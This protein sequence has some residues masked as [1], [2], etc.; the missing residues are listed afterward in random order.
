M[1]WI[2]GL[3]RAFGPCKSRHSSSLQQ[4]SS[5]LTVH[6]D[7]ADEHPCADVQGMDLSPIQ[8]TWV[9]PNCSFYIDDAELDWTFAENWFDFIH[10]RWLA[11]SIRDWP[12]LYRQAMNFLKRGGWFEHTELSMRIKSNIH[13][14]PQVDI[15]VKYSDIFD[16]A[17]RRTGRRFDIADGNQLQEWMEEA[18]FTGITEERYKIPLGQWP[19]DPAMKEVG[20]INKLAHIESLEGHL[21]YLLTEVLRWEDDDIKE[22]IPKVQEALKKND[23]QLYIEG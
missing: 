12:K 1:S 18:G 15:L 10:I 6:R 3:E 2:S 5:N 21:L 14:I 7:F 19:T 22:F 23:Q 17:E 9:P 20:I 16:E 11:G 13:D 8:P 4:P